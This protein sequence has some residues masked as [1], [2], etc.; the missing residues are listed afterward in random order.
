MKRKSFFNLFLFLLL[1]GHVH[2]QGGIG[3]GLNPGTGTRF[4]AVNPTLFLYSTDD[5]YI[6]VPTKHNNGA[7]LVAQNKTS[8]LWEDA[9]DNGYPNV[10]VTPTGN[11]AAYLSI[12]T[13][14]DPAKK[15]SQVGVEFLKTNNALGNWARPGLGILHYDPSASAADRV[16]TNG[17]GEN[18]N[19]VVK[20]IETVGITD[21]NGELKM[22]YRPHGKDAQGAP[23]FNGRTYHGYKTSKSF[24][25]NEAFS[26]FTGTSPFNSNYTQLQNNIDAAFIS[27]DSHSKVYSTG[28]DIDTKNY[29]TTRL[30]PVAETAV[31]GYQPNSNHPTSPTIADERK[32][33]R[34]SYAVEID[35]NFGNSKHELIPLLDPQANG[36]EPYSLQPYRL[37]GFEGDI[38][39]GL[40]TMYDNDCKF[41]CWPNTNGS[42][43]S[44]SARKWDTQW[45]ELA[46]STDGKNWKY[47]KPGTPF[48]PNGDQQ[49]KTNADDQYTVNVALP[50]SGTQF[51]DANYPEEQY[52]F[53]VSSKEK[54]KASNRKGGISL[55]KG[56]YGKMAGLISSSGEK[57]FQSMNPMNPALYPTTPQLND[58]PKISLVELVNMDFNSSIVPF[59]I[60]SDVDDYIPGT[61]NLSNLPSDYVRVDIYT[62]EIVPGSNGKGSL[63]IGAFGNNAG[64]SVHSK[65]YES[66]PYGVS[67]TRGANN[68]QTTSNSKQLI[69]NHLYKIANTSGTPQVV[70]LSDYTEVPVILEAKVKAATFYGFQLGDNGFPLS[71]DEASDF[72]PQNPVYS[73]QPTNTTFGGSNRCSE[74]T[75]PQSIAT[76]LPNQVAVTDLHQGSIAIKVRPS[77]ANPTAEQFIFGLWG[78]DNNHIAITYGTDGKY[79]YRVKKDGLNFV[80]LSIAPGDVSVSSFQNQTAT[81]TIETANISKYP[82]YQSGTP[83]PPTIPRSILPNFRVKVGSHSK[84][85]VPSITFQNTVPKDSAD[86][87]IKKY[88]LFASF[89]PTLNKVVIGYNGNGS[90]SGGFQGNIYGIEVSSELPT[91]GDFYDSDLESLL[92]MEDT[93]N[94]FVSN[95]K[96]V[97]DELTVYPNPAS[98]YINVSFSIPESQVVQ[99]TL[100]DMNGKVVSRLWNRN[101]DAGIYNFSFQAN[102]I[103]PGLYNMLIEIG[104]DRIVKKII[105]TK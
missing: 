95:P 88:D 77:Q 44:P 57:T 22:V 21:D 92:I 83:G 20:K 36:A 99:L 103:P 27:G 76:P 85:D 64:G 41:N 16:N 98:E 43:P 96:V 3:P 9:W 70:K 60:L 31:P 24:D 4:S 74:M 7:H 72:N 78:D 50:V 104:K 40:V 52:Y 59:G 71:T 10:F 15:N 29:F 67:Y 75:Q 97:S 58:L 12:F 91:N 26:F 66:V 42:W 54:H 18:T 1:Y 19:L 2:G 49:G 89:L 86:A 8:Y 93:P 63:L 68:Y 14:L 101:M 30:R 47:L 37:N 55:A 90:C 28:T 46:I 53:Y 51:H 61:A 32:Q 23:I 94:T 33:W 80:S 5:V 62:A 82:N 34:R 35:P 87:R 79:H 39:W 6:N 48:I 84:I 73:F 81:I 17:Q 25:A 102:M 38:Y 56:D 100:L 13:F 105:F 11:V 45:T 69:F 65:T